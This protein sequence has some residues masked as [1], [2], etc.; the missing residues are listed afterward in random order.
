MEP[1]GFLYVSVPEIPVVLAGEFLVFVGDAKLFQM[2]MKCPVVLYQEVV[3]PAVDAYGREIA[4]IGAFGDNPQIV[5][6]AGGVVA[7]DQPKLWSEIIPE[8]LMSCPQAS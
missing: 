4:F 1:D 8:G 5:L 6:S 7:V 3:K 2:L